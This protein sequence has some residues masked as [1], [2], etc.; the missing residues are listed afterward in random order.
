M[1][2]YQTIVDPVPLYSKRKPEAWNFTVKPS[3]EHGDLPIK[4]LDVPPGDAAD[5][6]SDFFRFEPSEPGLPPLH[7]SAC[8]DL[9]MDIYKSSKGMFGKSKSV[10]IE[11]PILL[12]F[13]SYHYD[14]IKIYTGF[15]AIPSGKVVVE[16]F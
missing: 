7:A 6:L 13:M 4:L 9:V 3:W 12:F 2:D 5:K 16:M 14:K 1:L 15:D 8:R 11:N 10:Y